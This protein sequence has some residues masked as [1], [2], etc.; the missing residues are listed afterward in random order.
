MI[1][2]YFRVST[3][4]Q[5]TLRQRELLKNCGA[6]RIYEEK[7][8]GKN[9]DRTELKNMLSYLREGDILIVESISRLARNTRDFFNIIDQLKEKGVI[10]KSL[11]EDIDTE[12]PRGRFTLTIFA[13]LAEL[14]REIIV[15]R[16]REGVA[17]AKAQGKY[18]GKPKKKIDEDKFKTIC[19]QWRNG[20]M[21][22]VDAMKKCGMTKAT[23]Y[24][25]VKDHNF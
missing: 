10:F 22:A 5:E 9:T 6:E 17:I 15:E 2:S 18:K 19:E 21:T 7:K 11:K 25:R 1:V 3:C 4:H 20:E 12:T 23:F 16:V 14:D 24:R 8:S 13:A